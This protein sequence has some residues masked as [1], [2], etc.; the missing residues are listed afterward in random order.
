MASQ[1]DRCTLCGKEIPGDPGSKP[2]MLEFLKHLK[3]CSGFSS[4]EEREETIEMV[5]GLL[6]MIRLAGSSGHA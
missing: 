4:N 5:L 3:W 6:E 1:A 2:W